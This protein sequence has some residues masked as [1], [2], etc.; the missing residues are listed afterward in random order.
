MR[1][2][3]AGADDLDAVWAIEQRVFGAEAW[4]RELL[5]EELGGPY[6]R[7]LVVEG[8][9][10]EVL[11]YG[12]LLVVGGDGDIQTIAVDAAARGRGLGRALMEEL[13]AEAA[14]RGAASVFLEVRADNPVARGLYASLGFTEIAVRERYYQPDDVDAIVMQKRMGA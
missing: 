6:R 14:R 12:G 5:R 7:Y 1:L 2:R 10:G 11:G 3:D 9:D 13:L 8:E 4:S